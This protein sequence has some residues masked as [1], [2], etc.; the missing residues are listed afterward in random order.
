MGT[1]DPAYTFVKFDNGTL[2]IWITKAFIVNN[3]EKQ[4]DISGKIHECDDGSSYSS[5]TEIFAI[6]V[7]K[8]ECLERISDLEALNNYKA[9]IL[10][11]NWDNRS[12][13]PYPDMVGIAPENPTHSIT[14]LKVQRKIPVLSIRK[15]DKK[16]FNDGLQVAKSNENN[17]Y[18]LDISFSS[19]DKLLEINSHASSPLFEV[20]C[21]FNKGERCLHYFR[22]PPNNGEYFLGCN[23]EPKKRALMN[24]KCKSYNKDCPELQSWEKTL[25]SKEYEM[26]AV[27]EGSLDKKN[28]YPPLT[29]RQKSKEYWDMGPGND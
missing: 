20:D 18:S 21:T 14:K 19:L 11:E 10:I 3:P 13:S 7:D 28:V 26:C 24:I 23:G 4:S 16:Y 22:N 2:N 25:P 17:Y 12:S 9:I 15:K 5:E 27:K 6:D 1:V 8:L 29:C